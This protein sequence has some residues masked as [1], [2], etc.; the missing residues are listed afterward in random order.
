MML[1][2]IELH[3]CPCEEASEAE[4]VAAAVGHGELASR[5]DTQADRTL[6][7]ILSI[8]PIRR[9]LAGLTHR[10]RHTQI[11]G[12]FRIQVFNE[13]THGGTTT[14]GSYC[15]CKPVTEHLADDQSNLEK[16]ET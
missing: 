8:C 15:L 3:L 14:D 1:S 12:L 11:L 5:Q 10:R 7:R 2:R 13:G 4:D 6:L 9:A 16:H